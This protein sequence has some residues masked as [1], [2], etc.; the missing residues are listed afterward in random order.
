MDGILQSNN[1]MDQ[2]QKIESWMD[3][4]VKDGGIDRYDDLH[5]DQ[6]DK[7]WKARTSWLSAGL[8]SYELAVENRNARRYE[9]SVVLAFPLKSADYRLGVDFQNAGQ[10]ESNFQTTPPSLYLF[11][12]GTEFWLQDAF[13][14]TVKDIVWPPIFGQNQ[15][16]K[17]S[18]YMEFRRSP[19]DEYT[20]SLFVTG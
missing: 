13:D 1:A 3:T 5:V 2:K 12:P 9:V 16:I 18:V 20:R 10:L 17:R 11:R 8:K 6:I 15:L 7:T 4:I 14:R 19:L